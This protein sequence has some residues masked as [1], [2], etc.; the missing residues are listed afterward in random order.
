MCKGLIRYK[1]I[2][3]KNIKTKYKRVLIYISTLKAAKK[4][5]IKS[6]VF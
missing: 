5:T 3:L 2:I 4:L 1:K 6:I